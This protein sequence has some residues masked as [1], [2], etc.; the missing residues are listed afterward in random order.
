MM[1]SL[2][3]PGVTVGPTARLRTGRFRRRSSPTA[4]LNVMRRSSSSTVT[5]R[6]IVVIRVTVS[7]SI[8]SLSDAPGGIIGNT[9][10]SCSMRNSTSAG[11]VVGA[12]RARST[13]STCSPR[14]TRHAGMPYASARRDVVGAPDRRGRVA[15]AVEELLPLPHHAQ[16]PVVEDRHLHRDLLLH[17]RGDLLHVHLEAA[18]ARDGPHR[19]AG[20]RQRDAHGRRHREA[21]GAEPAGGDVGVGPLVAEQLRHPHLVLAHVGDD[22]AAPGGGV[23]ERRENALGR[24][25]ALEALH[26]RPH[27]ARDLG[28]PAVAVARLDAPRAARAGSSRASPT[29][30]TVTGTFFPISDASSSMWMIFAPRANAARLPVTRSSNRSPIPM[31]RSAC[32]MARLTCTSPCMPGMP[33]CSG[34]DSGNALM[35]RSVVMTG[36]PVRSA[37]VAELVVGVAQDHAVARP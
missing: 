10:A 2:E 29:R 24:Q 36:M 7:D 35:P 37:S 8:G 30:P 11:P 1:V 5:A 25:P 26:P 3:T 12:A 32:W 4:R 13:P 6:V 14:S 34:C 22:R 17:H 19:L 16:V 15:A 31:M 28:P 27:E 9:F 33:R 21:H 23:L 20:P 18:I